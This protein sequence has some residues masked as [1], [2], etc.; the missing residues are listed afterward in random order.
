MSELYGQRWRIE[1]AFLQVKR[2]LGLAYL[3]TG[4][5]NGIQLQLWATWL[6]YAVLVDLA[7]AVAEARQCPLSQIS[8]EML[9]RGLYH[10]TVAHAQG[11]ARDPVAYF[12][13]PEN[14]DLGIV[15]RPRKARDDQ[16][17]RTLDILRSE[18]NL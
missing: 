18:L 17:R 5:V 10:F 16:R 11:K 9:F 12:A 4:S 14:A 1:D 7:D 3:W 15:K 2:L 6:L 13:A 8:L